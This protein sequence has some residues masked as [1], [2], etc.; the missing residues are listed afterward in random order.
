MKMLSLYVLFY[1][2]F[3][4]ESIN[5][6]FLVY[7]AAGRWQAVANEMLVLLLLSS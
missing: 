4:H 3:F 7:I 2:P 1:V 5:P 6:A